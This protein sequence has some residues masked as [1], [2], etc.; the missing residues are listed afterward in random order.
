MRGLSFFFGSCAAARLHPSQALA[1]QHV[2]VDSAGAVLS[3]A[4][5]QSAY[6]KTASVAVAVLNQTQPTTVGAV[7]AYINT[8]TDS[9]ESCHAK[10]YRF[11]VLLNK[12][13]GEVNLAYSEEKTLVETISSAETTITDLEVRITTLTEM[14]E[15][16][17]SECV[18][19]R[20]EGCKLY[21]QYSEELK[22]LIAIGKSP[23]SPIAV[24]QTLVTQASRRGAGRALQLVG[25]RGAGSGAAIATRRVVSNSRALQACLA[26]LGLEKEGVAQLQ[27][28]VQEPF[29]D[30]I[31]VDAEVSDQKYADTVTMNPEKCE[32]E[33]KE[34]EYSWRKAFMVVESLANQTSY[35]C[36]S[37]ECEESIEAQKAAE[38]PMLHEER[39]TKIDEVREAQKQ[40]EVVK[41]QLEGLETSLKK[42][43][44]TAARTEQEC[45]SMEQ[46]SKYLQ[47]VRDIL[48]QLKLCPG[49]PGATF[50]IAHF[51]AYAD[52]EVKLKLEAD[53]AT[54]QKMMEACKRKVADES[55]KVRAANHTEILERV[56]DGLPEINDQRDPVM[57][58]CKGEDC[59]G[60]TYPGATSG[61]LRSCFRE[62]VELNINGTSD[63][64]GPD[65]HVMAV[66]VV[67][68]TY[69]EHVA[70]GDATTTAAP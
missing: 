68:L 20:E 42:V 1:E 29:D 14:Y 37:T 53:T 51:R 45:G 63:G 30:R 11:S 47:A 43:E 26:R 17:K 50:R 9:D 67:D 38:L 4:R 65:I 23:A 32:E 12:L 16:K 40:L 46:G 54:D 13:H 69:E 48:K 64:C 33:R 28:Q 15:K 2:F 57:G 21:A 27:R 18:N 36:N 41:E 56:I 5:A 24:Y 66:C 55:D 49:L 34:L 10:V 22:E 6:W 60:Q 62:Q 31:K 3:L 44:D 8:Q 59:V 70:A 61:H 7:D 52:V 19:V 58:I 25:M 35:D 39:S